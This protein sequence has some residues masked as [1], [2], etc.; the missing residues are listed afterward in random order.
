MK[1]VTSPNLTQ[2]LGEDQRAGSPCQF[3]NMPPLGVCSA[4]AHNLDGA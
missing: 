2:D 1:K 3:S 4:Q